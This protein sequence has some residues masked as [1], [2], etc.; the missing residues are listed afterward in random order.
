MRKVTNE[1][2][3]MN[4]N[5]EY[6]REILI[7]DVLELYDIKVNKNGFF[8]CLDP[9]HIDKHPSA[10]INPKRPQ[11]WGCFSCGV[12]ADAIQTVRFLTGCGFREACVELYDAG[13]VPKEAIEFKKAKEKKGTGIQVPKLSKEIYEAI[14][15]KGDPNV[16]RLAKS[17]ISMEN[18]EVKK[19]TIEEIQLTALDAT[20]IVLDKLLDY[21][22]QL[23]EYA[24]NII[25]DFPGLDSK[26]TEYICN[27]TKDRIN[28]VNIYITTYRNY[29][30]QE[31]ECCQPL[32]KTLEECEWEPQVEEVER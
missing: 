21:R 24:K 13:L 7:K 25:V 17:I 1:S 28:N 9:S 29:I 20:T 27:T 23:A 6:F 15:L 8:V 26:A 30:N 5:I 19:F 14:G 4:I 31:L 22:S 11:E 10:R 16:R 3:Y 18:S 2:E 12:S 32:S